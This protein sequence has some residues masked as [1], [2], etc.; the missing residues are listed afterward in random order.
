M[1]VHIPQTPFYAL[2]N[3]DIN[4]RLKPII[5]FVKEERTQNKMIPAYIVA[6]KKE[7]CNL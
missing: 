3:T 4:R 1:L 2:R 7:P 6:N 5:Y